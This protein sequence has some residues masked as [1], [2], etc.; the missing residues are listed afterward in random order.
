ME[1]LY[2][3]QTKIKVDYSLFHNN[4]SNKKFILVF[5]PLILLASLALFI[6][7]VQYEP[8]TPET[9]VDDQNSLQVP[10][11]PEDALTGDKKAPVT[12]IA[13]EDFAC[14]N[15]KVQADL[16]QTVL[17]QYPKSMKVIWKIMPITRYP[18]DS[19][20]AAHYGYCANAQGKFEAFKSYAFE[21]GTA[22]SEANLKNIAEQIKLDTEKLT[23]CL[24]SPAPKAYTDA[25][26][27]LATALHIQ[28]LPTMFINNKQID[29]P[30]TI[31]GWKV[32]LGI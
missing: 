10:I 23:T 22:L 11:Y 17:K 1:K 7:I 3:L 5:I 8:L 4:M 32:L 15:C 20:L 16:I 26:R 25:T 2:T 18:I 12:V 31:D 30:Q 21:N 13:F 28:V 29:P 19:T 9:T 27:N 14:E 6:R 24:A